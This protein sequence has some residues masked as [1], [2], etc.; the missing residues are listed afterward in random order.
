MMRGPLSKN[1]RQENF[2][3][4]LRFSFCPSL[5]LRSFTALITIF[6]II[7]YI[8][9][10]AFGG[11]AIP[12]LFLSPTCYTLETFGAQ[13]AYAQQQQY[14]VWRFITPVFLHANFIHILFNMFS[15]LLLGSMIEKQIGV[16]TMV[17]CYFLSA[18]GGNLLSSIVSPQIISVGASTAIVGMIGMMVA[19]IILNWSHIPPMI[20][21]LMLCMIF[22]MILFNLVFSMGSGGTIAGNDNESL[23]YINSANN[24]VNNWAHL[25]GGLT[26]LFFGM[27]LISPVQRGSYERKVKM[28]GTSFGTIS[29]LA[30]FIVFYL[31]IHPQKIYCY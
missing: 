3:Q 19:S 24:Q 20:R 4:M 1:P 27:A 10:L 25:G 7:M 2:W 18:I 16:R 14:Q 28:I 29:L 22:M 15:Q 11:L 31:V 8:I 5:S 9:T 12:S 23:N 21:N 17:M 6:D 30:G 26:G 13:N